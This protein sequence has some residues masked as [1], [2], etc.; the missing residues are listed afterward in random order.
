MDNPRKREVG[1]MLYLKFL[2]IYS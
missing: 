1:Q 2:I